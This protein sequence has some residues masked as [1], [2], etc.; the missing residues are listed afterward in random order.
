MFTSFNNKKIKVIRIAQGL[1]YNKVK[2]EL[3][4]NLIMT[5]SL[6]IIRK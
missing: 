2:S 1:A 3:A 6:N 5:L 4:N